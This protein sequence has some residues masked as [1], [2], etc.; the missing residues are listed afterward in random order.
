MTPMVNFEIQQS[1]K[2]KLKFLV[3]EGSHA[4]WDH[5]RSTSNSMDIHNNSKQT[6]TNNALPMEMNHVFIIN[7][8]SSSADR[9]EG[10]DLNTLS[11]FTKQ[12]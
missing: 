8:N 2:H 12:K 11:D 10:T 5:A 1:L 6:T 4:S 3:E 9:K 7:T